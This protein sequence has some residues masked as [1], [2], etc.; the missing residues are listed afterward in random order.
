MHKSPCREL[1]SAGVL[2]AAGMLEGCVKAAKP[3][4][5]DHPICQQLAQLLTAAC[6]HTDQG[7]SE[8]RG[9]AAWLIQQATALGF[10]QA[11]QVRLKAGYMS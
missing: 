9:R 8:D 5:K 1:R 6:Q 4:A 7:S 2:A 11:N 3:L 10:V